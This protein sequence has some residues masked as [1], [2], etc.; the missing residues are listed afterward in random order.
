MSSNHPHEDDGVDPFRERGSPAFS[1]AQDIL[2]G[3]FRFDSASEALL[4]LVDEAYAGLPAQRLPDAGGAFRVE[5][6]LAPAQARPYADEPPRVRTESGAG[7]LCGVIDASNYVVIAPEQHWALVV[8]SEDMLAYPYHVRYE[9]IEFAVFV[10]AA[11]GM[12]L[13]PLHG[14]C[15]G[16]EGR[17]V[18]LLG[19]SGAGKSTLALGALCDGLD[20]LA[21]DAVFVD[22]RSL[23]ML[24]V[25]NFVHVKHDSLRFIDDAASRRWIEE[26]PTIR[27]RSGVAKFEADLRKAPL[28]VSTAALHLAAV[29]FVSAEQSVDADDLLEVVAGDAVPAL[30]AADQPYASGQPGWPAFVARAS[31]LGVYRLR[32]GRHPRDA[33]DALRGL[34]EATRLANA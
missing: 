20:F 34:L 1:R 21:E 26:A 31:A 14:A 2:G 10:L 4:A 22:P 13:V 30:L 12:G 17:G 23:R 28:P 15:V 5:L 25:G 6:R 27:R 29:V 16:D 3:R 9:L 11:R 19:A 18:L 7:L 32:R 8:V 33:V 24:G